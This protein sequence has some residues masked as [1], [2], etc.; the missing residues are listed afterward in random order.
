V[1]PAFRDLPILDEL[2]VA[3]F[4]AEPRPARAPLRRLFRGSRSTRSLALAFALLVLAAATAGAG[5]LYLLRGSVIPAPS[6]RDVAPEQ[7]PAPGTSRISELRV[8]DPDR[9][10]RRGR[11]ASRAAG[12]ASCAA[13]SARSA[14]SASVWWG[15][16]GA[17]GCCRADRRRLRQATARRGVAHRRARVR[18]APRG[19]TCARSSTA[20]PAPALRRVDMNGG[21]SARPNVKTASD[22]A[23]LAVLRGYPEDLGIHVTL[24][25]G[26][27]HVERTS[28]APIASSSS[29][30]WG[31]TPGRRTCFATAPGATRTRA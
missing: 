1:E 14:T 7:T 19:P 12:R 6:P 8:A 27:G 5:T 31:G 16:T 20:S 15:S 22:G 30:R 28:S 18:R 4:T 17:S 24:R 29:T 11:C 23:F 9:R 10:S 2:G 21:R 3:L 26:D 25:F 13:R